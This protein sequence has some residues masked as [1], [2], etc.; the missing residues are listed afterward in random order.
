[1][2][3]AQ[4]LLEMRARRS[5]RALSTSFRY[6]ASTATVAA[7][8]AGPR[9]AKS[10]EKLGFDLIINATGNIKKY[11]SQLKNKS[12][13]SS[14]RDIK[15]NE[16]KPRKALLTWD[17]Y[18]ESDKETSEYDDIAQ[19]SFMAKDDHSDEVITTQNFDYNK[20]EL[21]FL[22]LSK[23]HEKLKLKNTT[24]KKKVLSLL[25]IVEELKGEKE[26]LDEKAEFYIAENA[27]C[28][29]RKAKESNP[30]CQVVVKRRTDD[31]PP[32][33]MVTF[34]NGVE[35]MFDAT[36]TPTQDIRNM[37]LEKG[38]MLETEQMF[39]EAGEKWPV[40]IP[41]EELSQSFPG[42]KEF[43]LLIFA[44]L[45][46]LLIFASFSSFA[47]EEKE[48]K[49]LMHANSETGPLEDLVERLRE[50]EAIIMVREVGCCGDLV[51]ALH[52]MLVS[53]EEASCGFGGRKRRQ[54]RWKRGIS[55]V[56][57]AL[58]PTLVGDEV[59]GCVCNGKRHQQRRIWLKKVVDLNDW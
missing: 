34:V 21:A 24:L 17:D 15:E 41:E 39:K 55:R 8:I 42:T 6:S 58:N 11:C 27:Q 49:G 51:V 13:S 20:L 40:V 31:H 19:L 14:G 25:N 16:F 7:A 4:L 47:K 23:N 32:Q 48:V 9:A 1:M 52:P 28:N 26:E 36:A 44:Y 33:I 18:D 46:I 35:E 10:N 29:A 43:I 53:D 59:V 12:A 56:I 50:E 5:R 30:A 38:Q 57:M 2:I 45:C 3:G 54:L 37:I 22:E